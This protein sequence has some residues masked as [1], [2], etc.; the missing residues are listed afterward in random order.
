LASVRHLIG[1]FDTRHHR[2]DGHAAIGNGDT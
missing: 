1:D 2:V